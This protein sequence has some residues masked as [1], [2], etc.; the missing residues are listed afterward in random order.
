[1]LGYLVAA[2]AVGDWLLARTR[3]ADAASA[4]WRMLFLLVALVAMALVRLLPWIG[5]VAVFVLFL[6]GL[7][8]FALRSVRGY[9]GEPA[10][11]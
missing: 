10:H 9:R 2:L 4:G 7:G 3:P 1:M 8:A 6:A 11:G 5:D